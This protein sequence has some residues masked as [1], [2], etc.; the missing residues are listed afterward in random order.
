MED[1]KVPIPAKP[2]KFIDQFRAFIR[3]DGK[4]YATENTYVYWVRQLINWDF[5]KL[6][7]SAYANSVYQQFGNTLS[8]KGE[9][10]VWQWFA[11]F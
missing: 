2:L 4:S 1:V 8:I 9:V 5:I 3:L 11:N 7:N 10:N 6:K